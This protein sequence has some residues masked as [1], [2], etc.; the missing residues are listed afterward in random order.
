MNTKQYI[1]SY[2]SNYPKIKVKYLDE[3]AKIFIKENKNIEDL[4]EFLKDKDNHYP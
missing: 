1:D 3:L 4:Q 2:L